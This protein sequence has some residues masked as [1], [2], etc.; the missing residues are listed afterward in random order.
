MVT[1]EDVRYGQ[2]HGLDRVS[3]PKFGIDIDINK[4]ERSLIADSFRYVATMEK[5]ICA[6]TK[7]FVGRGKPTR[8][9]C[10]LSQKV[11]N[12]AGHMSIG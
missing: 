3:S 12:S 4:R 9:E 10:S 5:R 8:E 7:C 11:G 1:F 2:A 6:K